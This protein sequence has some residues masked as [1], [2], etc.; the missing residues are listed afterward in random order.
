MNSGATGGRTRQRDYPI[1]RGGRRA[2]RGQGSRS[3]E[4]AFSTECSIRSSVVPKS[5]S[6]LSTYWSTSARI[7]ATSAAARAD[8]LG[9]R[10][11]A[12][13]LGLGDESF[14]LGVRGGQQLGVLRLG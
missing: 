8:E 1:R 12:D 11:A 6:R 5:A 9:A 10:T 3:V 4:R 2:A 7:R 13:D 14:V